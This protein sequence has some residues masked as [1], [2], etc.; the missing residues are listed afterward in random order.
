M[1]LWCCCFV[2]NFTCAPGCCMQV[3]L[4]RGNSLHNYAIIFMA[5]GTLKLYWSKPLCLWCQMAGTCLPV[6]VTFSGECL[7]N[8]LSF[9]WLLEISIYNNNLY[10][11]FTKLFTH[12]ISFNSYNNSTGKVLLS[13][14]TDVK[15]EAH[16][17]FEW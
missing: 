2:L 15:I 13:Q 17:A 10:L 4:A 16:I 6:W 3:L 5:F 14:V 9:S 11:W 8:H 7:C 12:I 1:N